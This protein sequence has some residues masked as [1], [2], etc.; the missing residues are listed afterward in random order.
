MI[1]RG[2]IL[3]VSYSIEAGKCLREQ[4]WFPY[5]PLGIFQTNHKLTGRWY[6]S[7]MYMYAVNQAGGAMKNRSAKFV[8]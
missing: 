8:M 3:T 5:I 6:K 7:S 4:R 2:W 1:W